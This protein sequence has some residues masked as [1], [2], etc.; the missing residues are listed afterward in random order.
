MLAFAPRGVADIA[1][2]PSPAGSCP[3]PAKWVACSGRILSAEPGALKDPLRP[4]FLMRT[5]VTATA[6]L[7]VGMR[8]GG[9]AHF[10][11]ATARLLVGMRLGGRVLSATWI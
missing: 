5:F 10:V 1:N 3:A 4:H 6:R 9:N 11:I 8:P 7:L 2:S